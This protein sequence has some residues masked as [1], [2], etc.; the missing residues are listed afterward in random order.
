L[1]YY[2]YFYLRKEVQACDD[3]ILDFKKTAQTEDPEIALNKI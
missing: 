2:Y 1:Y 3:K